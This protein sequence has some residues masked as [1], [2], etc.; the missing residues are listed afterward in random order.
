LLTGQTEE[1]DRDRSQRRKGQKETQ[2]K[3]IERIRRGRG[4]WY[5]LDYIL[6]A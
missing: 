1:G 6:G 3:D 5:I 4:P 2:E